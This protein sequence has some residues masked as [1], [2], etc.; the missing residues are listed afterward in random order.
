M[1]KIFVSFTIVSTA[2]FFLVARENLTGAEVYRSAVLT[3]PHVQRNITITP[4]NPVMHSVELWTTVDGINLDTLRARCD[5]DASIDS[6]VS[7]TPITFIP[8]NGRSAPH[9]DPVVDQPVY[10]NPDITLTYDPATDSYNFVVSKSGFGLVDIGMHLTL[11]PDGHGFE[12]AD[13]QVFSEGE[14]YTIMLNELVTI[15]E[16]GTTGASF[17]TGI[18]EITED[19]T[20]SAAHY[21]KLLLLNGT[22]PV[23]TI[24]I[25]AMGSIPDNTMFSVNTHGGIQNYAAIDLPV[26][27]YCLINRIQRNIIYFRPGVQ[28]QFIKSGDTLIVVNGGDAFADRGKRVFADGTTPIDALPETGVWYLKADY[29]GIF[30][31]YVNTL[32]AGEFA[33]GADDSTPADADK[34]K[35][36][37]GVN[38]FR[39]PDT[40]G[41]TVKAT[42]VAR[43]SNSIEDEEVGSHEHGGLADVPTGAHSSGSSALT[44]A[45]RF[46]V[47]TAVSTPQG[48]GAATLTVLGNS[49]GEKNKID[50]VAANFYRLI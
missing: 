27:A 33:T 4:V 48:L 21:G 34:A 30:N 42:E 19:T 45:V 28:V 43:L 11:L 26:S 46:L 6:K 23:I 3:P 15:H 14:E 38:K 49:V 36:V 32:N 16:S 17:P 31:E 40:R 2:N 39:T 35:F 29:P 7:F 1:G 47:N 10:T 13:G 24:D 18:I 9:Y 22:N 37:I 8:G 44:G 12:W 50:N 41:L 25:T 20:F 5:V